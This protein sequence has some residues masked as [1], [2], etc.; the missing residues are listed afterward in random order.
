MRGRRSPSSQWQ[1]SPTPPWSTS[2]TTTTTTT[3]TS[4]TWS[5]RMIVWQKSTIR[6][7][8]WSF[9]NSTHQAAVKIVLIMLIKIDTVTSSPGPLGGELRGAFGKHWLYRFSTST[10]L[11]FYIFTQPWK[12]V[13]HLKTFIIII[14]TLHVTLG[15]C[16]TSSYPSSASEAEANEFP[17]RD[18][19]WV[20]QAIHQ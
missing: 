9:G 1:R 18:D 15:V 16:P 17:T 20:W 13:L 3:L 14:P 7:Q 5:T 11:I 12:L 10:G 19:L 6:W 8:L 2:S 4:T